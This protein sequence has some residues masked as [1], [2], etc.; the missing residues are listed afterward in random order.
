MATE[1]VDWT[2]LHYSRGAIWFHWIIAALVIVN[3]CLGLWHE[4]FSKPVRAW[5]MFWHKS[6]GLTVLALTIARFA[7]RLRH[8][9]PPFDPLMRRWET[10]LASVI[11]WLFYAALIAIPLTGWLLSSTGGKPTSFFGLFDLA[12]LPVRG[13]DAKNLFKELHEIFG[14]AMIGLIALHVLG[15]L[16]HHFEGHRHLIGRMAPW[17]YRR[18]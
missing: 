5:M 14:K 18:A 17:L 12:P 1:P 15:A 6:L 10:R 4:D 13:P 2:M 9:P 7:W 11:H 8:R 16:K 3:L